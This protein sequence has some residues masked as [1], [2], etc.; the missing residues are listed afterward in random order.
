MTLE[1]MKTLSDAY[2]LEQRSRRKEQR[3]KAQEKVRWCLL[4]CVCD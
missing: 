4:C 2:K 3:K 1:E